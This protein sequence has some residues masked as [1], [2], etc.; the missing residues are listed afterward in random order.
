PSSGFSE[1]QRSFPATVSHRRITPDQVD[2]SDCS[3]P[4]L[5]NN[6]PSG[7][8]ARALIQAR[9][10]CSRRNSFPLATSHSQTVLSPEPGPSPP[11]R[12]ATQPNSF[13][14]GIP[15]GVRRRPFPLPTRPPP[16]PVDPCHS[17]TLPFH[18][19]VTKVRPSAV[20][21][22]VAGPAAI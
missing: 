16:F 18:S 17:R 8:N 7:E 1:R 14:A 12:P 19:A 21:A 10:T 5:A 20:K 22:I 2:R 13:Q 15:A 6:L 9:G 3:E 4:A 11:L